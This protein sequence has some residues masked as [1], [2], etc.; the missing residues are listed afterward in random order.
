M[1]APAR[2]CE[3]ADEAL[4]SIGEQVT[5][6][7]SEIPDSPI[8]LMVTR[9]SQAEAL[10][11]VIESNL[12]ITMGFSYKITKRILQHRAPCVNVHPSILPELVGAGVVSWFHSRA[13]AASTKRIPLLFSLHGGED[14]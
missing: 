13:R 14:R 10:Y 5:D 9:P 1:S 6:M 8:I 3:V 12:M 4:S 7:L 11:L 2:N